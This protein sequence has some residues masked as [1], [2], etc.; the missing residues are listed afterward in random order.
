[1]HGFRLNFACAKLYTFPMVSAYPRPLKQLQ[2]LRFF[3][4][5]GV[6]LKIKEG[7]AAERVFDVV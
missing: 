5:T 4:K 2:K 7:K 1:M 3:F 6:R